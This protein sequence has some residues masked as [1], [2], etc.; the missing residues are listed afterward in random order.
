M[1]PQRPKFDWY[2]TDTA[3]VINVLVKKMAVEGVSVAFEPRSLLFKYSPPSNAGDGQ[4]LVLELKFPS[5]I[6]PS[7]CSYK[8]GAVKAEI[9]LRKVANLRWGKLEADQVRA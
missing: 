9:K 8:V 6:V 5:S 1:E 2:E 3:I 4:P 7:E